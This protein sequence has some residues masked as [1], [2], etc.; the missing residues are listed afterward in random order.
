MIG[1]QTS[2][3]GACPRAAAK[4][5]LGR[6]RT[7]MTRRTAGPRAVSVVLGCGDIGSAVAL[8]LHR[9]GLSVVL[10]DEADPAWHRRGMAFTDAWYV[11]NAELDGERACFCAS[12]RSI[13][14]V[15]A[16]GM[17]AATTWSWPAVAAALDPKVLVDARG[18]RRRGRDVL[19]GSV[20]VTIGI[21]R[22]FVAGE[23]VDLVIDPADPDIAASPAS[24]RVVRA[25]R[26]GRFMT[27]RRIGDSVR[28]GQIVGGLGNEVAAAPEAGVLL[29]LA[30]R[31]ARIEPGDTL[32]EIDPAGVAHLCHGVAE[33]PRRTA[34]SVVA[35]L[36]ACR[37]AGT[38]P[39]TATTRA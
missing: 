32:V 33:V 38:R 26:H 30:A 8:A 3:T 9:A 36:A 27:E 20:S 31:G 35:A 15:L 4:I 24:E 22:E 7:P 25:A 39:D 21:G 23:D 6:A 34:Q 17:I 10:A 11:G 18:R 37:G 29:G 14:S 1:V 28:A 5:L 19:A 12:L 16:S 13:P 2:T